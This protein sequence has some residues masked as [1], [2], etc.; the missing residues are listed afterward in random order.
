MQNVSSTAGKFGVDRKRVR[1]WNDKYESL[2][3]ANIGSGIK[4]LHS[5]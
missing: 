1:E 3:D 4:K 2:V 5:T